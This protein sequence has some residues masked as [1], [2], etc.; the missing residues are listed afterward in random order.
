MMF[1]QV[2]FT[3]IEGYKIDTWLFLSIPLVCTYH[4]YINNPRIIVCSCRRLLLYEFSFYH[5]KSAEQNKNG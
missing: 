3:V 2:F 5:F 1:S 4:S